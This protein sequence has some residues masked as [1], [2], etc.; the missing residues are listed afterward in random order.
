MR[1]LSIPLVLLVMVAVAPVPLFAVEEGGAFGNGTTDETAAGPLIEREGDSTAESGE[2]ANSTSI[3]GMSVAEAADGA[4]TVELLSLDENGAVLRVDFPEPVLSEERIDGRDYTRVR[5]PGV[6]YEQT[7]G[8]PELPVYQVRLLV[9]PGA[10][11]TLTYTAR[12]V[13]STSTARPLPAPRFEE[14]REND[15]VTLRP[16]YDL[17]EPQASSPDPASAAPAARYLRTDVFRG[18]S[19]ARFELRPVEWSDGMLTVRRSMRLEVSFGPAVADRAADGGGGF[20]FNDHDD[21]YELLVGLVPISDL[22]DYYH[23]TRPRPEAPEPVYNSSDLPR[24]A[25]KIVVDA[26]G[27]YRVTPEDLTAAGWDPTIIDPRRLG[28]YSGSSRMLDQD[29]IYDEIELEAV[30]VRVDGADDGSFDEGDALYFW[31]EDA[32]AWDLPDP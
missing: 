10:E 24:P 3:A 22:S 12:E 9:P 15:V 31:G 21:M 13:E 30:P 1:T 5:M 7:P 19:L 8:L 27:V 6:D 16:V 4:P 29:Y 23:W 18:W 28:L 14:V 17:E 11:P 32:L 2:V 26:D 20:T 25:L